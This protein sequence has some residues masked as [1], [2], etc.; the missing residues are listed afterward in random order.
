MVVSI[1]TQDLNCSENSTRKVNNEFDRL[2]E[3][4]KLIS[5]K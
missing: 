1:T 4:V 2:S 3:K 5:I